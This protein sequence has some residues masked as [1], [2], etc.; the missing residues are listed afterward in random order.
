MAVLIQ[1]TQKLHNRHSILLNFE[2]IDIEFYLIDS[3]S[4]YRHIT[5]T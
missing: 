4:F 3:V 1:T 2:F 5:V